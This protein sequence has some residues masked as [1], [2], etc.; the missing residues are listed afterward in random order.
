MPF[1]SI[2]ATSGSREQASTAVT[3]SDPR[4]QVATTQPS[5]VVGGHQARDPRAMKAPQSTAVAFTLQK[6]KKSALHVRVSRFDPFPWR[7]NKWRPQGT[8]YP[9]I[10]GS[11]TG[12]GSVEVPR[13]VMPPPPTRNPDNPRLAL[14]NNPA[15]TATTA[16][17]PTARLPPKFVTNGPQIKVEGSV[18]VAVAGLAPSHP[19][20]NMNVPLDTLN[21]VSSSY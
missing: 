20:G 12:D 9:A 1:H 19:T 14:G 6:G 8:D 16:T 10:R 13:A 21:G 17:T 5:A 11:L 3:R 2:P 4:R 18:P 15:L 7:H